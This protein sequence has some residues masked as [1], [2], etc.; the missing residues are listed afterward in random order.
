MPLKTKLEDYANMNNTGFAFIDLNEEI[1]KEYIIGTHDGVDLIHVDEN[2]DIDEKLYNKFYDIFESGKI[3]FL[4]IN[5]KFLI[6][7]DKNNFYQELIN[8]KNVLV[9]KRD[10]EKTICLE[11]YFGSPYNSTENDINFANNGYIILSL[12]I[13]KNSLGKYLIHI[14]TR[15]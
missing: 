9:Y 5:L 2:I 10:I 6:N 14:W 11:I 15:G 12:T 1:G 4:K 8:F 13:E 7:G 3:L